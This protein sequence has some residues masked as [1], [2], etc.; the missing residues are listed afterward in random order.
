MHFGVDVGPV[1]RKKRCVDFKD[2]CINIG[3]QYQVELPQ[4]PPRLRSQCMID[5]LTSEKGIYPED[6]LKY[7]GATVYG[8]G[9]DCLGVRSPR[10]S[11][12]P[13]KDTFSRDRGSYQREPEHP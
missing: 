4:L 11:F 9:P 3:K 12:D 7:Y 6:V 10:E 8:K 1:P 13:S 5:G 2:A